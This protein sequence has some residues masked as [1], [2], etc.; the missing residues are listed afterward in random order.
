MALGL[1]LDEIAQGIARC[2]PVT[3]VAQPAV[4]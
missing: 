3:A 4:S 2:A 1:S